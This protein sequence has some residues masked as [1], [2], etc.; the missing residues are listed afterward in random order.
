MEENAARGADLMW[1]EECAIAQYR[2]EPIPRKPP[3]TAK[4]E[5]IF[6]RGE[7]RELDG[8][9]IIWEGGRNGRVLAVA[10]LNGRPDQRR[11][12]NHD[13]Q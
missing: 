11:G 1:K 7:L 10:R 13:Q 5:D 8:K 12:T 2:P 3:G 6:Q 4:E 9:N